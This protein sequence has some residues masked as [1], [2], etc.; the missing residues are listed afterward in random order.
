MDGVARSRLAYCL[1]MARRSREAPQ[2]L[3][4]L[5][6]REI[7]RSAGT[8]SILAPMAHRLGRH[9]L[10]AII[11]RRSTRLTCSRRELAV[12]RT[13]LRFD[14]AI[15]SG[16]IY[17]TIAEIVDR[18]ALDPGE[19]LVLVTVSGKYL[20]IFGLWLE[21]A[22]KHI[23]GRILGVAMDQAALLALNTAL[24][25]LTI[26]LSAF[27]L[28]DERGRIEDRSRQAL[29]VL[30]VMLLRE[31][32]RRGH[33]L[34]SIDLDAVAVADLEPMLRS[35]PDADIVAQQDYS[36]PMDVARRLGFV[37]CCGFMVLFPTAATIS[38]LDRY[39]RRASIE[40]DDQLA[41]NH[42]IEEA[43]VKDLAR[44]PHSMRFHAE[45]IRWVCPDKSLVSREIAAGRV[46]RHF[47]QQEQTIDQLRE[48]LGLPINSETVAGAPI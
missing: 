11:D 18:L 26:D 8:N 6:K 5:V 33:R 36:I 32:V 20:D 1:L 30:R 13:I 3:A 35:L 37:L 4:Q 42:M 45:G 47:L 48:Q 43:G 7:D 23:E 41:I 40:L 34:L 9:R 17:E 25:G 44:T 14:E 16:E 28:F 24:H 2:F 29:W 21:Q 31:I 15:V 39:A 46:V 12:A 27:F 22:H 19:D 38:F 10:A